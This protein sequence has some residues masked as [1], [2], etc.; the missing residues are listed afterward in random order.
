M[1]LL[2]NSNQRHN[3]AEAI[4]EALYLDPRNVSNL[5]EIIGEEHFVQT[6][7]VLSYIGMNDNKSSGDPC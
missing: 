2:K 7:M 1:I 5:W 3:F 4:V 6:T